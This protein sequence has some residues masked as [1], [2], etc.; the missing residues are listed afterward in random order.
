[1]SAN[2][3]KDINNAFAPFSFVE[4]KVNAR[5]NIYCH[6]TNDK[7]EKGENIYHFKLFNLAT[8]VDFYAKKKAF[9][10]SD[11]YINYKNHYLT[12]NYTISDFKNYDYF[13]SPKY[14]D[15]L[16]DFSFDK[17][18]QLIVNPEK[19]TSE[20]ATNSD[21][22]ILLSIMVK[23]GFSGKLLDV[24]SILPKTSFLLFALLDD[25]R[26]QDKVAEIIK[27]P[28]FKTALDIIRKKK[29]SIQDFNFLIKFSSKNLIFIKLLA[30]SLEIYNLH[31][32]NSR[33]RG[34]CFSKL[35][36]INHCRLVYFFIMQPD[37]LP[38]YREYLTTIKLPVRNGLYMECYYYRASMFYVAE[39]YP[40]LIESW[41][42]A[43]PS[44]I[45]YYHS[46]SPKAFI[47]D[48]T[49]MIKQQLTKK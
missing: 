23:C 29:L 49:K 18:L 19:T 9:E 17:A 44:K 3:F 13:S 36:P 1:M 22:T 37:L 32:L 12:N 14:V 15:V 33:Q 11:Y 20:Y 16:N 46:G 47:N 21:I 48:S 27:I 45:E 2:R 35:N 7:I 24:L 41:I 4:K 8:D 26:F 31:C 38:L 34:D 43:M 39:N 25:N 6:I 40:D 30:S 10:N 28:H 42:I 5:K